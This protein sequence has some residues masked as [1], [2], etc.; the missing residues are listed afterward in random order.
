[1]VGFFEEFAEQERVAALGTGSQDDTSGVCQFCGLA[2]D[3][4]IIAVCPECADPEG[5]G[6]NDAGL[7]TEAG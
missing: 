3:D 6:W 2:G 1:M 4:I 7:A 5:I